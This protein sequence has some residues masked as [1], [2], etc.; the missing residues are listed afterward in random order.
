MSRSVNSHYSLNHIHWDHGSEFTELDE[1]ADSDAENGKG[2]GDQ[3][4]HPDIEEAAEWTASV[5]NERE[6]K[7]DFSL[8]SLHEVDRFFSNFTR[9]DLP[10]YEDFFS[11]DLSYRSFAMGAYVGEV[12]R[13]TDNAEW[14]SDLSDS[15]VEVNVELRLADDKTCLPMK[16]VLQRLNWGPTSS[17]AAF[18]E[19]NGFQVP[20]TPAVEATEAPAQP[21]DFEMRGY[22]TLW[23]RERDNY[24]E[25][26]YHLVADATACVNL[27]GYF[28]FLEEKSIP[29]LKALATLTEEDGFEL[30]ESQAGGTILR[31]LGIFYDPALDSDYWNLVE[32]DGQLCVELGH[33]R[34]L[35]F[36]DAITRVFLGND[37]PIIGTLESAIQIWPKAQVDV[38]EPAPDADTDPTE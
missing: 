9:S 14:H 34:L 30:P 17:F 4:S 3:F 25:P 13:R 22:L 6:Y 7:A 31:Q 12:L 24:N 18:A 20:G 5:L 10:G 8:E 19:E 23:F 27:Q 11:E 37:Y 15:L 21:A 33:D 36:K 16:Q 1:D 26:E 29:S 32:D 2:N 35:Q 38:E 28:A